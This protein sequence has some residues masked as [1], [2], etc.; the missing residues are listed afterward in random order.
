MQRVCIRDGRIFIQFK[1]SKAKNGWL[2]SDVTLNKTST[3]ELVFVGAYGC[4]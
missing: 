1:N 4:D 2:K 3:S